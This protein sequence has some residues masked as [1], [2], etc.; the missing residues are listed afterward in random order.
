MHKSLIVLL[1][2]FG[3]VKVHYYITGLFAFTFLI[4]FNFYLNPY[5]MCIC[6]PC[7]TF[8]KPYIQGTELHIHSAHTHSY[9]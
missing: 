7:F 9:C 3:T 5:C 4:E 6:H 8:T 2:L 1:D